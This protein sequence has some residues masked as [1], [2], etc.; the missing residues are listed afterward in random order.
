MYLAIKMFWETLAVHMFYIAKPLMNIS[1][2]S[3]QEKYSKTSHVD[4]WALIGQVLAWW[5]VLFLIAKVYLP[6]ETWNPNFPHPHLV[7]VQVQIV[8]LGVASSPTK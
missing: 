7:A 4:V 3:K 8:E 6:T 1:I 2:K 5:D